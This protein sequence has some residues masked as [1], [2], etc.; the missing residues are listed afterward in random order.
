M[1]ILSTSGKLVICSKISP[2]FDGVPTADF[3]PL[4]QKHQKC[5]YE[6]DI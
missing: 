1:E 6:K 2:M 5:R 4:S 3:L